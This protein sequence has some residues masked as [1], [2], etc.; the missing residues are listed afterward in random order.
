MYVTEAAQDEGACKEQYCCLIIIAPSFE[1]TDP[2]SR[3]AW[4]QLA[5]CPKLSSSCT[6]VVIERNDR[7]E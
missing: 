6:T 2:G 5:T 3:S 4:Q 1:A 7:N